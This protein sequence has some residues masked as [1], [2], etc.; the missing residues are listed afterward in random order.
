MYSRS[1]ALIENEKYPVNSVVL[2]SLLAAEQQ[3]ISKTIPLKKNRAS[4]KRNRGNR[5]FKV[6]CV[7]PTELSIRCTLI[8]LLMY[9]RSAAII[10]NEKYLNNMIV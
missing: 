8:K 10:E 6:N 2:S 5:T 4:E 3:H 1:A 7:A 9:S